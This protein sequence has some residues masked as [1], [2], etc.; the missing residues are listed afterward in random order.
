L[1]VFLLAMGPA[2]AVAAVAAVHL[3]HNLGKFIL[4]RSHVDRR[5]LVQ[6]GAPALA[7]AALGAWGLAWLTDLPELGNWSLFGKTFSLCPLK[8]V[9]GLSLAVFSGWE[10][11]GGGGGVRGVPL[12]AGGLAS[13]LL[14]G[15]TGHQ[16]AIRSAFFLGKDL[17][18][19]TFI[20]TGA[21]VAC[22]VDITRIAVYVQLFHS[23]GGSIPW[24]VVGAGIVG[25]AVGLS[26]GRIGLRNAPARTFRKIIG[27]A[28]MV[29]GLGL[30]SGL[31]S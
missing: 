25:A 9:I 5:V 15:L 1:P 6:F 26:V 21:A 4:L 17:P 7:A 16:G 31:I 14:G 11:L 27:I 28:L 12:W 3:F 8:L 10:L 18:K 24:P 2:P 13:G 20:A 19:E 29:F 23:L 22:A 30:A